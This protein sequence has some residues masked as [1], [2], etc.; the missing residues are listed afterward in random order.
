MPIYMIIGFYEKNPLFG[1]VYVWTISGVHYKH[2]DQSNPDLYNRQVLNN[3]TAIM[4]YQ[5]LFLIAAT[6]YMVYEKT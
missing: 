3:T 5:G 4:I 2:A 6:S 1:V